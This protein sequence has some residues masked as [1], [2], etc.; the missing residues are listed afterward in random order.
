MYLNDV[1]EGGDTYFYKLDMSVKPKT[2]RTIVWWNLKDDGTRDESTYHEGRPVQ[3]GCKY[4]ETK[5]IRAGTF[6]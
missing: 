5:W 1:E 6:R 3:N 2:G 4:I